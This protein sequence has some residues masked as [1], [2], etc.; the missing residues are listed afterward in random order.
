VLVFDN[1]TIRVIA[2]DGEIGEPYQV[3]MG[4]EL[5]ADC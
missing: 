2:P 4:F 3:E 1:G 5:A